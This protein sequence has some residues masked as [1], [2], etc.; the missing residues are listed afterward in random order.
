MLSSFKLIQEIKDND[1]KSFIKS[2]YVFKTICDQELLENVLFVTIDD[3]VFGFGDN[4]HGVC[5]HGHNCEMEEPLVIPE[6]TDKFI[7]EFYN[8]LD[9]VLAR[10]SDNK[11]FSWGM[12]DHGQLGI[13]FEEKC[14][15]FFEPQHIKY[16]DDVKIMQV[17]CGERHSLVLTEEG[18]V[19]G[20]GDNR[21]G[22]TGV[23][24]EVTTSSRQ[25]SSQEDDGQQYENVITKPKP[26]NIGKKV[27]KIHCS[28]YQSFA[29]TT[30]GNVYCCGLNDQC[31]LGSQLKKDEKV[32][33]PKLIDNMVNVE[34]IVT[35]ETNAYFITKN[36]DI[37]FHGKYNSSFTNA[38]SNIIEIKEAK[39]VS[40]SNYRF[41]CSE[42][43]IIIVNNEVY[44]L[45]SYKIK[46]TDYKNPQEY[47]MKKHEVT[48]KTFHI[49]HDIDDINSSLD[50]CKSITRNYIP[51]YISYENKIDKFGISKRISA[52]L[53]KI[54]KFFYVFKPYRSTNV[55]FVTIDDKVFA[56]GDN[57]DGVLGLGHDLV[58]KEPVIIPELCD[59]NVE[60]FYNGWHFVLCLTKNNNLFSWGRNQHGQLGV[61]WR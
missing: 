23:G 15:R 5:G 3:K 41:N 22:Q 58:V 14:R 28:K 60:K 32:F 53:K 19:Y 26:W 7:K 27:S 35:S 24:E 55:L 57:T 34:S 37:Y 6:L 56:L 61:V 20:W 18:V 52:N 8:G 12:N 21:Y 38:P 29:I 42:N 31:Q 59:K 10:A 43:C 54:I 51:R 30:D 33:T 1:L 49:D 48:Y 39:C 25:S 16:F 50:K 11:L 2:L 44:E 40:S 4:Q 47:F 17:C 36:G 46:K 45:D 9:F 13:G